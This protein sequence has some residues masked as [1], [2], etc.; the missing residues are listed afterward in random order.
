MSTYDDALDM[1]KQ[2]HTRIQKSNSRSYAINRDDEYY[3]K[4]DLSQR[5]ELERLYRFLL[6]KGWVEKYFDSKDTFI[7]C[8]LTP[9]GTQQAEG[10]LEKQAIQ[11]TT[12]NIGVANNSIMGNNASHNVINVGISFEEL[13][14]L[15]EQGFSDQNE[16]NE[17]L[18]TLKHLQ[19]RMDSNQPLEKGLLANITD[20]IQKNA[21]I[22]SPI[23]AMVL[24][25]LTTGL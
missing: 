11:Q 17:I 2:I 3:Q 8:R 9:L 22:S 19:D 25:Y 21:W 7:S 16:R 15:I 5:N 24:K 18:S 23:T 14:S 4:M 13:R 1:L 6:D 10:T 12:F 20:I